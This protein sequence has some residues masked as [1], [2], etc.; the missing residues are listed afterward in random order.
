MK[1]VHLNKVGVFVDQRNGNPKWGQSLSYTEL[2]N[3]GNLKKKEYATGKG[4]R[5]KL[6]T[7]VVTYRLLNLKGGLFYCF[8]LYFLKCSSLL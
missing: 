4:M 7:D 2:F 8:F 5:F 1:H 6:Y 3:I